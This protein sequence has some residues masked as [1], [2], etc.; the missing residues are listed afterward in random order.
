[1]VEGCSHWGERDGRG[2]YSFVESPAFRP[3]RPAR[4][5]VVDGRHVSLCEESN[6]SLSGS[7]GPGLPAGHLTLVGRGDG[8]EGERELKSLH[9]SVEMGRPGSRQW[10]VPVLG[11]CRTHGRSE[12]QEGTSALLATVVCVILFVTTGR[13]M[14]SSVRIWC[15]DFGEISESLETPSLFP[16]AGRNCFSGKCWRSKRSV[17]KNRPRNPSRI[18]TW[19]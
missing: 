17:R 16:V 19:W 1:M 13:N 12:R 6:V 14:A 18:H 15:D 8:T 10:Q 4:L 7:L 3:L 9:P 11:R 5:W 2:G